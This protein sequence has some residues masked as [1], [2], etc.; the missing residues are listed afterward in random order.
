[1]LIFLYHA[2]FLTAHTKVKMS[3][4]NKTEWLSSGQNDNPLSKMTIIIFIFITK[5]TLNEKV[6]QFEWKQSLFWL[7]SVPSGPRNLIKINHLCITSAPSNWEHTNIRS[8]QVVQ[9][10]LAIR[11]FL[12]DL[13]LFLNAK[14]SLSLWSKWQIGHR[15]WYQFVPYQSIPSNFKKTG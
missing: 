12:F 5:Q 9:L 7:R 14:S 15:K 10:N 2:I 1:M 3:H 4:I 6:S 8:L 13:K 11:N